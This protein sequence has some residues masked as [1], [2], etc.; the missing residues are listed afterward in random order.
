MAKQP[1][2]YALDG[3]VHELSEGNHWACGK[4]L[5]WFEVIWSPSHQNFDVMCEGLQ[6]SD[7]AWFYELDRE[8][9][10]CLRDAINTALL[11][12]K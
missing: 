12:S 8:A 9:L 6:S 2:A 4:A 5:D 10:V 3:N 7:P 11:L 1:T